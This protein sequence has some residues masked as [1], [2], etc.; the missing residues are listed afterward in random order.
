MKHWRIYLWLT[1]ALAAAVLLIWSS[2]Y[3]WAYFYGKAP[4]LPE[5]VSCTPTELQPG[6]NVD[7]SLTVTLPV[8][9]R[10]V[11]PEISGDGIVASRVD[12][13]PGKW[14][15][16]RRIWKISGTFTVLKTG[17]INDLQLYFKTGNI[18]SSRIRNEYTVPLMALHA[19]LAE[20]DLT[21]AELQL[22][23][24]I[25]PPDKE[26]PPFFQRFKYW[27]IAAGILLISAITGVIWWYRRRLRVLPPWETAL[28]GIARLRA[29][30]AGGMILPERG[31]ADLGDLL[32]NYLESRA[33]L[34]ASRLTTAEV[35]A[36]LRRNDSFLPHSGRNFIRRFLDMTDLIKFADIRSNAAAFDEAAQQAAEFICTTVPEVKK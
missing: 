18:Y 9:A 26:S 6:D 30:V 22:A 4:E 19:E 34:P 11:A 21:E 20:S 35:M 13:V 32:R 17:N 2:G 33:F 24:E 8:T 12:A 3:L 7:A 27:L 1:A 28:T 14:L 36:E 23:D 25:V 29:Q 15:W 5:Q 10:I 16:N 31:F